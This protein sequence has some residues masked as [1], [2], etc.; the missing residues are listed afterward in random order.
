MAANNPSTGYTVLHLNNPLLSD[1][2]VASSFSLSATLLRRTSFYSESFFCLSCFLQI[3]SQKWKHWFKYWLAFYVSSCILLDCSPK[4]WPWSF[5]RQ[6]SVRVF[7]GQFPTLTGFL[8][9]PQSLI[10]RM[11]QS[12]VEVM[13]DAKGKVQENLLANGGRFLK[14]VYD[15]AFPAHSG[16]S[17]AS[18]VSTQ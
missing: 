18:D 14:C 2:P 8:F 1:L 16:P 13:E 4:G 10:K 5:S 9:F 11:A 3:V 6:Q 12:V 15:G 7:W 17:V